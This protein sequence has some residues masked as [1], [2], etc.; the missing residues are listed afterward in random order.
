MDQYYSYTSLNIFST[1][2]SNWCHLCLPLQLLTHFRNAA[3]EIPTNNETKKLR[4]AVDTGGAVMGAWR[5]NMSQL[6]HTIQIPI[7]CLWNVNKR[8]RH[9]CKNIANNVCSPAIFISLKHKYLKIIFARG[10]RFV[11]VIYSVPFW[12]FLPHPVPDNRWVLGL[13][14][15]WHN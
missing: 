14:R 12:F 8:R 2:S 11:P 4:R 10:Q 7:I 6:V 3:L 15:N 13:A 5:V 9:E 1:Q